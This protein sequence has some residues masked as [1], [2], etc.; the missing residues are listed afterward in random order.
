VELLLTL[1]LSFSPTN[2]ALVIC[3]GPLTNLALALR[4]AP[5][6]ARCIEVVAMGGK[7]G[8]PYPDWNLRCDPVA[9]RAVLASGASVTLVGMHVTMGCQLT[10][11]ELRCVFAAR[12]PVSDLLA[13]C[14]LAWRTWQRRLPILHDA[15]TV[16]VACD[17]GLAALEP[18]R[19]LVGPH[20]LSLALR[21]ARPN[22]LVCR[23]VD[24]RRLRS[25]CGFGLIRR[26]TA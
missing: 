15:L 18:R 6:L 23:A 22:A 3:L 2:K 14:T 12:R 9:A 5:A 21:G 1:S 7:L 19:V 4:R 11:E 13:R 20:G 25:P 26:L 16:A 8:L 24:L 10:R 17:P